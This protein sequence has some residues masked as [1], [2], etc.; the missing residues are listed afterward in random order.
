M[1][2]NGSTTTIFSK[3]K[4]KLPRLL[5]RFFH[6]IVDVDRWVRWATILVSGCEQ[7][8]GEYKMPVGGGGGGHGGEKINPYFSAPSP[9]CYKPH[10]LHPRALCTLPS[11]ARNKRPRW[12]PVELDNERNL[13]SHGKIGDC[14]QSRSFQSV[15]EEKVLEDLGEMQ[16]V[17]TEVCKILRQ[18]QSIFMHVTHFLTTLQNLKARP[19]WCDI[20][21]KCSR[22]W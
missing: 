7:N 8:W 18:A 5:P 11:F 2:W 19:A 10:Y 17:E 21:S 22:V 14:E 12:W 16:Q 15:G 20:L 13:R 1:D 4:K 6:E 9:P 3:F